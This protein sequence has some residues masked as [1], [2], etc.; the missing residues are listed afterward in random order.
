M[1]N[2]ATAE[3]SNLSYLSLI[4]R[5]ERQLDQNESVSYWATKGWQT[6]QFNLRYEEFLGIGWVR[7]WLNP[8]SCKVSDIKEDNVF[9][10]L[11]TALEVKC[12]SQTARTIYTS[13]ERSAK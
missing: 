8:S 7:E 11:P 13:E 9:T 2:L 3:A 10:L 1:V 6:E 5:G 12:S 4:G